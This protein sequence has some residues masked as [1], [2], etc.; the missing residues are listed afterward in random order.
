VRETERHRQRLAERPG[1][2]PKLRVTGIE[3]PQ[4]GFRLVERVEDTGRRLENYCKRFNVSFEFSVIA[5]KWETIQL[6]DL[7][8]DR[9][10]LTVVNCL[11]R[12]RHLPNETMVAKETERH[13]QRLETQTAA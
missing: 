13:R 10:E 11:F 7:K 5:K 3:L 6:E 4:P 12:L 9:D 2:A 1:G 8:I